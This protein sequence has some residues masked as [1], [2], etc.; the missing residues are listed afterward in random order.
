[1]DELRM[2]IEDRGDLMSK[3]MEVYVSVIPWSR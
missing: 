1:M 3:R 2:S